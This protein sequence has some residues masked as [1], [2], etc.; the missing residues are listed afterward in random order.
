FSV[1]LRW[2]VEHGVWE[3]LL[4][5]PLFQLEPGELSLYPSL[6]SSPR[7]IR[8]RRTR[9]GRRPAGPLRLGQSESPVKITSP[10]DGSRTSVSSRRSS[11]SNNG[12]S[13]PA[14]ASKEPPP[15]RPRSQL[16]SMKRRMEL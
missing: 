13:E 1:L 8:G 5:V 6:G 12:S 4:P 10:E 15:I 14:I 9:A 16:S 2:T 11:K 3:R 7:A